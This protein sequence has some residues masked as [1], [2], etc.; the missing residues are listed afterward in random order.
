[1]IKTTS[2]LVRAPA[3]PPP[4]VRSYSI[5]GLTEK[6]AID[7]CLALGGLSGHADG[8]YE[9]FSSLYDELRRTGFD[10]WAEKD[11]RLPR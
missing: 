9:I 8:T 7:L 5:S 1:M 10:Y 6:Q 2:V 4:P 3:P 11:K